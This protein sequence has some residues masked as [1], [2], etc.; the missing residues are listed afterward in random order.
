MAIGVVT[1]F[2]NIDNATCREPPS[3]QTIATPDTIEVSDPASNANP[4]PR[5]FARSM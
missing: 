4:M 5:Q 1:D 2:D 3:T